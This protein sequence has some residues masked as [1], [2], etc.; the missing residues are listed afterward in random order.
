M[1]YADILLEICCRQSNNWFRCFTWIY[2]L[3]LVLMTFYLV[4]F[5][6]ASHFQKPWWKL[7]NICAAEI[8]YW[9]LIFILISQFWKFPVFWKYY[10]TIDTHG[11]QSTPFLTKHAHLWKTDLYDSANVY[12]CSNCGRGPHFWP[13][14]LYIRFVLALNFFS[15]TCSRMFLYLI[16]RTYTK[17]FKW[18]FR[19]RIFGRFGTL[20]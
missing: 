17:R 7:V 3:H 8:D 2:I 9:T 16:Y 4:L 19:K 13:I 10:P 20:L 11:W 14:Q 6:L 18:N 5:V 12:C 1:L 15:I